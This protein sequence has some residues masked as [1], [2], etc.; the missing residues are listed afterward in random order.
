[1]PPTGPT[2]LVKGKTLSQSWRNRICELHRV[3]FGY[4]SIKS[5][6]PELHLSTI[7]YTIRMD[8]AN[9]PISGRPKK[10]RD[11]VVPPQGTE[12]VASAAA[13]TEDDEQNTT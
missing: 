8:N 11:P 1:M 10:K 7:K 5:Q 12:E 9:L 6:H 4:I 3:G 2:P 13:A